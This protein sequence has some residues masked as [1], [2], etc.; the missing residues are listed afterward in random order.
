[1]AARTLLDPEIGSRLLADLGFLHV[2]GRPIDPGRSY[3][4]VALREKPTLRHFDPE[5]VDYWS[6]VDGRGVKSSVDR[7]TRACHDAEYAWGEIGVVDRKGVANEFVSF[8]GRLTIRRIEGVHVV[9]F[10][11]AAPIVASGGHSQGWDPGAQEMAGFVGRLRAAAGASRALESALAGLPPLAVYAAFVSDALA[12]HHD[13]RG[14]RVGDPELIDLV[15]RERR[16]I[17]EG[18]PAD[19]QAGVELASR[20]S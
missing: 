1:M 7:A 2:P 19:W 6:S 17:A 12:R 11:S 18:S 20:L 13:R 5:R 15:E 9:V 8:G 10:V 3:L 4:M 14:A 16:W